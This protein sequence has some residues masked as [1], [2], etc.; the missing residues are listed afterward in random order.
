MLAF[1]E[2]AG[3]PQDRLDAIRAG[4]RRACRAL[5]DAILQTDAGR[6]PRW[7]G[8]TFRPAD[9]AEVMEPARRLWQLLH[10]LSLA[11]FRQVIGYGRTA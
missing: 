4:D 3:V 7:A 1:A 10:F 5:L 2:R 9:V 8:V 6:W 11:G